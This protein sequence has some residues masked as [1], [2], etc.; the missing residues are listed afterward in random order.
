VL[1]VS[2]V[3]TPFDAG[4]IE[5]PEVTSVRLPVV[6][7]DVSTVPPGVESV[8]ALTVSPSD[9]VEGVLLTLDEDEVVFSPVGDVL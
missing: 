1:D 9:V 2:P 5:S 6:C 7:G 4:V 3:D 8:E